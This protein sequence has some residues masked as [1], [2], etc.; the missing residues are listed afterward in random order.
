MSTDLPDLTEPADPALNGLVRALTA[1]GTASELA[2]RQAALAMFRESRRRP[3][4]RRLAFSVSTAAAAIVL[5]GG[6]AAAYAAVL[7]APVQHI[8]SRM[9]GSIGVPDT[10]H[11]SAPLP[12]AGPP[13][14]R[15]SGGP[16]LAAT[17]QSTHPASAAATCP[18]QTSTPRTAAA[19]NLTLAAAL[20]RIPANAGDVFSGRLAS[21]GRP[22]AGVRVQLSERAGNG[23]A[24]RPAGSAVTDRGG[25]VTVIVTHLTRNA[26]FRLTVPGGEVSKPVRVTVIPPVYVDVVPGLLPGVDRLT[27]WVP[28]AQAG[29]VVVLQELSGGVWHRVGERVLGPGHLAVFRVVTPLSGN[30]QYRV[31]LPAT[32]A[33]G[34]SASRRV[35]VT[36]RRAPL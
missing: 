21:G 24:W 28:F 22:E 12:G 9:L 3:R 31:V 7:P 15:S 5:A 34:W 18:C 29:D 2:G 4:R 13:G 25:E 35:R 17:N 26:S 23:A 20:T 14:G 11:P 8:A 16:H 30:V 36:A 33:H 1:D 6:I 19:P 27:A 32:T 10:H